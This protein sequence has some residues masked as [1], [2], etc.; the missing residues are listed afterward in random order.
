MMRVCFVVWCSLFLR[1]CSELVL[2]L[3]GVCPVCLVAVGEC[4]H[5]T[6]LHVPV[7]TC[8]QPHHDPRVVL[9]RLH[10]LLIRSSP[11]KQDGYDLN[12]Q[13]SEPEM[14]SRFID[15][16]IVSLA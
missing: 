15:E 14:R 8:T 13:Q 2:P 12:R 10:E 6:C 7:V 4:I 5:V 1:P 11:I 3:G 16:Y 9:H